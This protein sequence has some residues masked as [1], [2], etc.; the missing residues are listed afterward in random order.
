[1]PEV[2]H[3]PAPPW[4]WWQRKAIV[5]PTAV[6]LIIA[7]IATILMV[8][9]GGNAGN[10]QGGTRPNGPLDGTFAADF[11]AQ[12][13][14]NG[15]PYGNAPGG[16]ETWVIKSVCPA[17]GCVATASRVSGS[18]STASTMVLDEV[19]GR[20]TAV[21]ATQGTCQNNP[22]EFWESM[23]LQQRPDGTL[24]GEFIVRS[25]SSCARNQHV[26][27]TRTGDVSPNVSTADP[28]TQ[29]ARAASPARGLH[30][31]YLESDRYVDGGR[32]AEANFDIQSYCLRTGERCLSYWENP[33]NVKTLLFAQGKWAL[34]NTSSD[35][36]CQNGGRAH[37]EIN[38]EYPLPQPAQ[39]P[40]TLL[41]GNGHYTIT[42]DC[43]YNSD[44]DSR[45]QRTGD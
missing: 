25:T 11:G 12:T 40:I 9:S 20:W 24:D 44:F 17:G 35:A 28:A 42:G 14:P 41:T 6:I 18:Q 2:V 32:N 33:D 23:S 30:G 10:K 7:A 21:N 15:Q 3:E 34:T 39:D 36:Q 5:I 4:P 1:M 38:L 13:M 22:T 8:L 31:R 43:P 26:T 16:R 19:G 37:R 45:V 27:F 29:P